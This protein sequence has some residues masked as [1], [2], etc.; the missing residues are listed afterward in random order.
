VTLSI[1]T[2]TA[3]DLEAAGALLRAAFGSGSRETELRRYLALRPDGWTLATLDG[4]AVGMGG[5]MDFGPFAYVGLMATRP[6]VRGKGIGRAVMGEL[7]RRLDARDCPVVLLDASQA[8][9]P[10]YA[11]LGFVVDDTVDVWVGTAEG[12]RAR[13]T[14]PA[15][16]GEARVRA[17]RAADLPTLAAY[18]ADRF[19]ADR[20]AVLA[21]Y[22]MDAPEWAFAAY[23]ASG[24]MAGFIFAGLTRDGMLG[25][26]IADGR[27]AAEALLAAALALP[28]DGPLNIQVPTANVGGGRL[29]ERHGF[30]IDRTL[31]H[32]RRGGSPHHE[33]R[34]RIYGQAS[35]A[36]G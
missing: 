36:I 23:D 2:L 15:D 10:L 26:W 17:L 8:G 4:A 28:Y 9:Y 1:R 14:P 35:F 21:S 7:L 29:L 11:S 6:D 12:V 24:E 20:R 33:R 3:G 5:A 32:M 27:D 34:L 13:R 31:R 25:P 30:R 18:D 22:F 16:A 19:G